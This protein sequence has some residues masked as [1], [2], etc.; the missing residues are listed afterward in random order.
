MK[1]I[2]PLLALVPLFTSCLVA[3]V[4]AGVAAGYI[5]NQQVL[6]GN[7]HQ[8]E[9]AFDVDQAWP[10]VKETVG[11]FAE[12]GSQPGVQ[13]FPRTVQAR[14]DGA[15]VTVEVEAVDIDRTLIRVTA[16]KYIGKDRSTA[17]RVMK[18]ILDGLGKE[19]QKPEK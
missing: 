5:I 12:P 19:H 13:D 18:G 11:Y 16:E 17:E 3:A 9:V 8:A 14:V 10:S 2:L 6:P 1:H 7:V 4:G 15:E